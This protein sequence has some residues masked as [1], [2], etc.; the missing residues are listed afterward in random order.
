MSSPESVSNTDLDIDTATSSGSPDMSSI[1]D[2]PPISPRPQS[3]QVA[4]ST[5][6]DSEYDLA[7]TVLPSNPDETS[8]KS[9]STPQSKHIKQESYGSPARP[10][11]VGP[12]ILAKPI[13]V[14]PTSVSV[15][16]PPPSVLDTSASPEI[17]PG[18]TTPSEGTPTI[19][20]SALRRTA[21]SSSA[22]GG[23]RDRKRLRFTQ[24]P[25]GESG[26]LGLD[27]NDDEQVYYPGKA[28]DSEERI[29][30]SGRNLSRESHLR[31]DPGTPNLS[32][33]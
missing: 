7:T 31:S 12:P 5:L 24:L 18:D 16:L 26:G 21:S 32:E 10:T 22:D 13:Q 8:T 11:S 15:P 28:S 17:P 30:G 33:T 14:I 2:S 27:T 9:F 25:H 29:A 1:N 6:D 4:P 19:A 3:S 20:P 23:Q